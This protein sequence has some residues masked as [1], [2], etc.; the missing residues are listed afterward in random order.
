[1]KFWSSPIQIRLNW[2]GLWVQ[3]VDPVHFIPCFRPGAFLSAPP[4]FLPFRP[5]LFRPSAFP[6]APFLSV[7]PTP[8]NCRPSAGKLL[9]VLARGR[10]TRREPHFAG[11]GWRINVRLAPKAKCHRKCRSGNKISGRTVYAVGTFLIKEV[12]GLWYVSKLVLE[13]NARSHTSWM[14]LYLLIMILGGNNLKH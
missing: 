14:Y 3:R 1:M 8:W 11:S 9:I 6:S 7:R 5:D 13:R 12:M 10:R 4:P 2:T